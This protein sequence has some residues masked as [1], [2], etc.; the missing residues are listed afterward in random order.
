MAIVLFNQTPVGY[1]SLFRTRLRANKPPG[2][3]VFGLTTTQKFSDFLVT[4]NRKTRQSD[5]A[6]EQYF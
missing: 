1:G 3:V 2:A 6:L 5:K 4:M